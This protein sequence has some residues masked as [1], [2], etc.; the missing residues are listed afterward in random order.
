[1]TAPICTPFKRG[2]GTVDSVMLLVIAALIPGCMAHIYLSGWG[3]LINLSLASAAAVFFEGCA[4]RLRGLPIRQTLG[5][6]SALITGLLIGLC[7]PPLVSIWIPV[8]AAGFAILIA[9]HAY[10]GLGNNVFNPAMAGYAVVLISF[11]RDLALWPAVTGAMQ[12]S[13]GQI[14][15][16]LGNGGLA[17]TI[18]QYPQWDAL[19]GAT[20]L[21]KARA[22][23]DTTDTL[24][25]PGSERWI[26]LAFLAGGLFLMQRR[27]ISWHIP[28]SL[29]GTLLLCT[30]IDN[31]LNAD[32]VSVQIHLLAGATMLGAFFIATDPVSAATGTIGRLI[33]GAG[34]GLLIWL[35][36]SFGGYP[37]SVAFAVL[38]LNCTVPIIDYLEP[39]KK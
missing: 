13:I 16:I 39:W 6:Y 35:I 38:L 5:D 33:Y 14:L 22:M 17:Q 36:R 12:L 4:C 37:D 3:A 32:A 27:V 18:T 7:L 11:P 28:V 31:A 34:I 29:L 30:L 15:D 25:G 20:T 1:M 2:P 8:I 9:K 10:G 19:T 26:N 21:D 23:T 24:A